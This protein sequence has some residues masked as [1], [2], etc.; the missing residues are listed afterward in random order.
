MSN[1]ID[2]DGDNAD[3]NYGAMSTLAQVST[4]N[5]RIYVQRHRYII[6]YLNSKYV[7]G[8]RHHSTEFLISGIGH[9]I[10]DVNHCNSRF[11]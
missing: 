8:L 5:N 7:V 2:I 3:K 10:N 4:Y 6:N 9:G 11:V 1:K